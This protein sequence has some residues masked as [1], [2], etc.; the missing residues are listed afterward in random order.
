MLHRIFRNFRNMLSSEWLV[1]KWQGF[2]KPGSVTTVPRNRIW[3]FDGEEPIDCLSSQV[4]FGRTI[5]VILGTSCDCSFVPW[6]TV[7]PNSDSD[8][9]SIGQIRNIVKTHI[10]PNQCKIATPIA[11]TIKQQQQYQP[12][13]LTSRHSQSPLVSGFSL[14]C[15]GYTSL[16]FLSFRFPCRYNLVVYILSLS[17]KVCLNLWVIWNHLHDE[18]LLPFSCFECFALVYPVAITP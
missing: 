18:I 12:S 6:V 7:Y 3:A 1:E 9:S 5:T 11:T 14:C 13:T 8:S 4:W 16:N 2:G 10:T 15:R 17:D